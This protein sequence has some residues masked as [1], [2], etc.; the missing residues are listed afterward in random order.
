M[1]SKVQKTKLAV[2]PHP[3]RQK[4][5]AVAVTESPEVALENFRVIPVTA[6]RES[7]T[8]PRRTFDEAKLDELAESIKRYGVQIPLKVRPLRQDE[9]VPDQTHRYELIAGARRLRAAHRAQLPAVPCEV[10]TAVVD[11][12]E[13][14][15]LQLVENADRVDVHPMEEA[16]AYEALLLGAKRTVAELAEKTGRNLAH[17]HKRL[18]LCKLLP[19]MREHFLAGAIDEARATIIARVPA[20]LQQ[21]TFNHCFEQN[22]DYSGGRTTY[23]PDLS[24]PVPLKRVQEWVNREAFVQLNRAPFSLKDPA[25]AEGCPACTDCDR[26]AGTT[27]SLFGDL[28]TGDTCT[29]TTCFHMKRQAIYDKRRGDGMPAVSTSFYGNMPK[30]VPDDILIRPNFTRIQTSN[31]NDKCEHHEKAVVWDKDERGEVIQICRSAECKK[32]AQR[33]E[34]AESLKKRQEDA[35]KQER[36]QA[37]EREFRKELNKAVVALW[38]MPDQK[39]RKALSAAI[40]PEDARALVY[41]ANDKGYGGNEAIEDELGVKEGGN[42]RDPVWQALKRMDVY[43]CLYLMI[44]GMVWEYRDAPNDYS[45]RPDLVLEMAKR[46]RVDIAAL[47]RDAAAVVSEREKAKAEK[48]EKKAAKPKKGKAA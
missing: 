13:Q 3:D 9:K 39:I 24:R 2:V 23:K 10:L 37:V 32:H 31:E 12:H 44:A 36:E 20:G 14:I 6:I 17:L 18:A 42:K 33:T 29:D 4:T 46:Y 35:K 45:G 48:A 5:T 11:I 43:E 21:E 15:E 16:L 30:N 19:E 38:Q 8:N 41:F 40:D 28:A 22:Y 47:R 7:Q 34:S 1:K 25:I 26:R 27:P